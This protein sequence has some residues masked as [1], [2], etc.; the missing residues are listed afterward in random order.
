MPT[1][2]AATSPVF[3]SSDFAEGLP[4]FDAPTPF[5]NT[6]ES[7]DPLPIRTRTG[8]SNS[9]NSKHQS[10]R[11]RRPE[12]YKLDSGFA[13]VHQKSLNAYDR[14][15]FEFNKI[16][17]GTHSNSVDK[18]EF[19]Q[20]RDI[21]SSSQPTLAEAE[22]EHTVIEPPSLLSKFMSDHGLSSKR[23]W[24]KM[25]DSQILEDREP[26]LEEQNENDD[27]AWVEV[28]EEDFEEDVG[29]DGEDDDA[30][31]INH[32]RKIPFRPVKAEEVDTSKPSTRSSVTSPQP[33]YVSDL[34]RH[35]LSHT[36]ES[37]IDPPITITEE[38]ETEW[39]DELIDYPT[40]TPVQDP[41]DLPDWCLPPPP[42][43]EIYQ[44]T[45]ACDS[46]INPCPLAIQEAETAAA[47]TN[48]MPEV[49]LTL[50]QTNEMMREHFHPLPESETKIVHIQGQEIRVWK[51]LDLEC[52]ETCPKTKKKSRLQ[53]SLL[54]IQSSAR[55][56]RDVI[57][58]R[59]QSWGYFTRDKG[60][61]GAWELVRPWKSMEKYR[62]V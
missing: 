32:A 28:G 4:D 46:G 52:D 50:S 40:P 2:F 19:M 27:G 51:H 60:D 55:D 17:V 12:P 62:S 21:N 33:G 41:D 13:T 7:S 1:T 34:R 5:P 47:M 57:Q 22:E 31:F 14:E 44:H 45:A 49:A 18:L 38:T 30:I 48:G 56:V 3:N 58:E 43:E 24:S 39:D 10:S 15:N 11:S 59:T 36:S 61:F 6:S 20:V 42:E 29:E 8:V 16:S 53:K 23:Q 37:E 25:L 26:L 9:S 54:K 35:T